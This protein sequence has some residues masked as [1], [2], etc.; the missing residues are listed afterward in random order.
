[1]IGAAAAATF[2]LALFV[3]PA[4]MLA[5]SGLAPSGETIAIS[6]GAG[7]TLIGLGLIDWGARHATGQL[8]R[9]LL[10]GNLVVQA[11]QFV[12]NAGAV[13]AGQLPFQT[14][15]ALLIHAALGAVFV[16]AMMRAR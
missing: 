8:Q 7:A 5:N 6:R 4:S 14:A 12:A 2:G 3:F 9:A 16:F 10:V 11:L 1:M 13:V 15:S